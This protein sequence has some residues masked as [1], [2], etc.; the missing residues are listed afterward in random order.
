MKKKPLTL[1]SLL[2]VKENLFE[3]NDNGTESVLIFYEIVCRV[4]F[5]LFKKLF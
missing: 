3:K 2:N 5:E 4:F 1:R